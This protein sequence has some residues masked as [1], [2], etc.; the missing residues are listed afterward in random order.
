MRVTERT[1]YATIQPLEK[2]MTEKTVADLKRAAENYYG[3]MYD[4]EFATFWACSNGDYSHLGD[5]RNPTSYQVYWC[6]RFEEF[7]KEFSATLRSLQLPP[8]ADER[9]ASEGLLK[10]TFGEA[11]LVFIQ[12]WFGLKSYREAERITLGDLLIAKRAAY[13]QDKFRRLLTNIQARKFENKK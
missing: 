7:I 1:L 6:K 3:G 4:L 13:N 2:Y 10:V 9:Q 12:Q 5:M 8:T 11:M